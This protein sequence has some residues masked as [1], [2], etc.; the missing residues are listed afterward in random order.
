[1][2]FDEEDVKEQS[3]AE[4]VGVK[5]A[6][7][8]VKGFKYEKMTDLM[9]YIAQKQQILYGEN[10]KPVSKKKYDKIMNKTKDVP[11]EW[12]MTVPQICE[13]N[14][15]VSEEHK[16]TTKDGYVLTMHRVY[17][18]EA[19]PEGEKRK[20][21]FMQHGMLDSSALWVIN[22]P[23]IAPAFHLARQG[24]DVWL[25]NNRGTPYGMEHETMKNAKKNGNF[26]DFT[27]VEMGRYDLPA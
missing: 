13:A 12:F 9:P 21:L 16:V 18:K 1:M 23:Q 5:S 11:E 14:G 20:A 24:Y 4:E 10:K 26:W 19:L 3:K 25:G 27:F 2:K 7:P 15:F 6:K 8:K 22:D 17:S